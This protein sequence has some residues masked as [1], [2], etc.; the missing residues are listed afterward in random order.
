MIENLK[1]PLR[2]TDVFSDSNESIEFHLQHINKDILIK[3]AIY[4]S[5]DPKTENTDIFN[6]IDNFFSRENKTIALEIKQR[7]SK[8]TYYDKFTTVI[9]S[10]LL[11][12]KLLE[13]S[14]S[15]T[16]TVHTT[17]KIAEINLF[18]A[19]LLIN[20]ELI[21]NDIKTKELIDNLDCLNQA[22]LFFTLSLPNHDI[23]SYNLNIEFINET[24][25]S[26]V[27]FKFLNTN[28][29]YNPILEKLL[30]NY[31]CDDTTSFIKLMLASVLPAIQNQDNN[32]IYLSYNRLDKL[33]EKQYQFIEKFSLSSF[34]PID[35]IDFITLRSNPFIR[36]DDSKFLVISDIFLCQLIH[37]SLY[38]KLNDIFKS[39]KVVDKTLPDFRGL[40]CYEFS[41]KFLFYNVMKYIFNKRSYIQ[42]SGEQ[43]ETNK[44]E[45][46]V[47][48][49]VRNGSKVLLF[50]SKNS[51]FPAKLKTSK[52]FNQIEKVLRRNYHS[53]NSSSTTD[54]K[55]ILQ[56][57]ETIKLSLNN[58]VNQ[59][60]VNIPKQPRF[61]PI[62]V[63]H[64]KHTE[65]TGFNYIL[66]N[67]FQVELEKLK[68]SL[69]IEIKCLP[70]T[71]VN[72]DTLIYFQDEFQDKEFDLFML[73]E[74]YHKSVKYNYQL[75]DFRNREESISRLWPFSSFIFEYMNE[76]SK[77]K[78]PKIISD[79]IKELEGSN[80]L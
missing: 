55:A 63:S 58:F 45:G 18:K 79:L 59:I 57:I 53:D 15:L 30:C 41:E 68:C 37:N 44:I 74:K 78:V 11:C 16:Q 71:V 43:F 73:I 10:K 31:N 66:N 7:I 34:Q 29:F 17:N 5:R 60:D 38:F 46:A 23:V 33:E 8:L 20:E 76:R 26:L 47:D 3:F 42:I 14:L 22:K 12:Y 69:N 62:L 50:E 1:I 40:Y 6:F 48:Y 54:K 77:M 49:Y 61:F 70:L 35:D 36:I 72:I 56:L 67:W 28:P 52:D 75:G 9:T 2:Y 21:E 13:K 4:F 51:L 24:Y 64:N 27:L 39:L 19:I 65:I 32:T 25:K 80:S